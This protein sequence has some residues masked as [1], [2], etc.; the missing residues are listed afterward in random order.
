MRQIYAAKGFS[1]E[2]LEKVVA[3]I[4][5]DPRLWV[6]TMLTE[7]LG[8]EVEG[9]DPVRAALATFGA[10]LAVGLV[11]LLPFVVPGLQLETRFLASAIGTAIAFFGV[12]AAKGIVLGRPALRAG[13]GTLLTG[14]AAALLAYVVGAWLRA[15][16]GA[17]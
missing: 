9:P 14:G 13:L 1:G 11:P 8:L 10:F 17:A 5:N 12:G 7:E 2:T 15:A 4:T 6:D 16:F 3:V